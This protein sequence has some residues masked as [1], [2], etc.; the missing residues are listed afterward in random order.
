MAKGRKCPVCENFSGLNQNGYHQCQQCS[1]IWYDIFS[2]QSTGSK[3]K[4]WRCP[5]CGNHTMHNVATISNVNIRRCSKC[6][7][8][9]LYQETSVNP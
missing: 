7:A 5:Y 1:A 2:R 6:A 4:G 9:V 8:T 3:G